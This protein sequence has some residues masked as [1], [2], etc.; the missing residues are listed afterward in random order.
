MT[1]TITPQDRRLCAELR[2]AAL[3]EAED[4]LAQ[5]PRVS[6][7]NDEELKAALIHHAAEIIT[8]DLRTLAVLDP[9]RARRARQV[10]RT[11]TAEARARFHPTATLEG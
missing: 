8:R 10:I 3:D 2:T 7:M 1:I 11:L 6:A 9:E 4:R 5:D